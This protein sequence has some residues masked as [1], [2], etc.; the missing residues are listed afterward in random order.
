VPNVNERLLDRAIDHAH[1]L[2]RYAN[3]VVRRIIALLNRADA[4]LVARIAEAL[5]RIEPAEATIERLEA[6]LSSVRALNADAYRIA[7]GALPGEMEALAGYEADW[8]V[9]TLQ[10]AI[11]ADARALIVFNRVAPAQAY[12]AALSRPFQGG[13]LRDWQASGETGR[14]KA[15]RD[16]IRLGFL[17]GKTTDEIIRGIRG[18]RAKQYK[19]GLLDRSRRSVETMVRTALSHTAATARD[20]VYRGNSDV[21]KAVRWVA[22]LDSRTSPM[23]RVRDGLRYTADEAHK[24]IDHKVPWLQ[25]PGRLHFGCRSVSVP[26]TRSFRELGLDIDEISPATRASMDGQVPADL[27]YSEWLGR[28]SAARQDEILG[29]ERGRLIRQGGLSPDQ[30]YSP[31]GDFLTLDQLRERDAS[32]FRRAGL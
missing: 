30:L 8:Q 6:I 10:A 4:D 27:T 21:I 11:P 19:D 32:A 22:T 15:V 29:P 17:E 23:C 9:R 1:D 5:T 18:T 16:A 13:L 28:Q 26:V 3:G 7:Y 31:R 25:G 2:Q 14:M 24:P 12:A 20:E